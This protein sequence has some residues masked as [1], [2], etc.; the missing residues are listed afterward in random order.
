MYRSE[1][2]RSHISP[3]AFWHDKAKNVEWFSPPPVGSV[4]TK[5]ENGAI[6]FFFHR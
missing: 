4:L 3:A 6:I 5:D 1:Y 2:D